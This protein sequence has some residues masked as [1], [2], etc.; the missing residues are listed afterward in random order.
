VLRAMT[1]SN[2]LAELEA[3]VESTAAWWGR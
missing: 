2:S 3:F 1:P